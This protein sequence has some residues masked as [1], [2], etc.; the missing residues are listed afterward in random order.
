MKISIDIDVKA[1]TTR[2][3][4]TEKNI[5]YAVVNALNDTAKQVQ[6]SE[7]ENVQAKFIMRNPDFMLRNAAIIKPFASVGQGRPYVEI[8]VGQ[9]PR[10]LL[11][12]FEQGGPRLP[13]VGKNVAVPIIGSP[14]RPSQSASVPTNM[15]I[16]ALNM[17]PEL[18]SASRAQRRTLKGGSKSETK[19][20]R[21]D[22][23]KANAI[24]RPW[25][26]NQRTYLIPGV[27]VFQ[28]TGPKRK[29]TVLL[30]RFLTRVQLK[31][32]LGFI[33]LGK[34]EGARM[35][36]SALDKSVRNELRRKNSK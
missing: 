32:I 10:L 25:Q 1:L 33:D 13:F 14:A 19:T 16:S 9:K 22:F 27:G 7:R 23:T 29:D 26:G 3:G 21:R 34:T 2:F 36:R 30:Y 12:Q 8:A 5:A 28:R 35:L 31:P 18:S 20:M 15:R 17:R 4:L 24:G 11:S 6:S